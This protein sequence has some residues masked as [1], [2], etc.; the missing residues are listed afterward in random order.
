M[1][2]KLSKKKRPLREKFV[3]KETTKIA[4]KVFDNKTLDTLYRLLN[5]RNLSSLEYPVHSGKEAVV[6]YA[7]APASNG[8]KDVAVKIFKFETSHFQTRI[9]YLEGDKRFK[10]QKTLRGMVNLF[11]RKEFLNL[12]RLYRAGI[13]VPKPIYRRDN[14]IIMEFVGENG[15]SAPTLAQIPELPEKERY[16]DEIVELIG[17]MFKLKLVHT[18]LSEFNIII[19]EGHPIIFDMSQAILTDHPRALDFL[20]KDIE[21]VCK[22]FTK[23]GLKSNS[24]EIFKKITAEVEKK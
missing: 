22:Y 7:K 21:H 17:R 5:N 14:I 16:F 13:P 23:I 2:M 8:F 19:W 20:K 11:A 12:T 3:L 15:H 10:S 18:D 4:S 6:F 1:S 24:N 9:S